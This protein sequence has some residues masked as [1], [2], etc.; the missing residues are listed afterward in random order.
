MELPHNMSSFASACGLF[1][2][3]FLLPFS[4]AQECTAS[5]REQAVSYA[6]SLDKLLEKGQ[7]EFV[8]YT[9]RKLIAGKDLNCAE[10]ALF[11]DLYNRS[12]DRIDQSEMWTFR[13][14]YTMSKIKAWHPKEQA[15]RNQTGEC[16]VTFDLPK[17]GFATNIR[18]TCSAN[19]FYNPSM[20]AFT[21]VLF[22]PR[23]MDEEFVP[24][25]NLE[26]TVKFDLKWKKWR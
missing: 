2:L 9:A 21:A 18:Q 14:R 6:T 8:G 10:T 12:Y 19:A 22:A 4:S 13:D 20:D 17:A 7:V 5:P 16:V 11:R 24:A 25:E 15:D 23:T 26:Y 3:M 1:C